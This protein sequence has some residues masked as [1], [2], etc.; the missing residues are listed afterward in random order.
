MSARNDEREQR[1]ACPVLERAMRLVEER[2]VDM[3][4]EMIDSD[5]RNPVS[6]RESLCKRQPDQQRRDQARPL[7]D[8]DR[9]DLRQRDAGLAQRAVEHRRECGQMLARRKLRHHAAMRRMFRN[10]RRDAAR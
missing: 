5:I 10:L 1:V 6:H 2:A 9:V 8:R 7:R 3:P 4:D